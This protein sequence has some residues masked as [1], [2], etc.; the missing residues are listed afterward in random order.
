MCLVLQ[1]AYSCFQL[2]S[3]SL[4]W[5]SQLWFSIISNVG[6]IIFDTH[7][8][9][10]LDVHEI[11]ASSVP[12]CRQQ[13]YAHTLIMKNNSRPT[14]DRY[15][16]VEHWCSGQTVLLKW[17]KDACIWTIF[18]AS[19]FPNPND[20]TATIPIHT[21]I[22]VWCFFLDRYKLKFGT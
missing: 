13:P 8:V 7:N 1:K 9:S 19:H 20:P 5:C 16:T 18:L 21:S 15:R 11:L 22:G 17:A 14:F 2:K 10:L 3:K 4:G 12:N 6:L